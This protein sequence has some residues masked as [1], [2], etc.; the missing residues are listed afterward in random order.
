MNFLQHLEKN[1]GHIHV[2]GFVSVEQFEK[3]ISAIGEIIYPDHE[4]KF[5]AWRK[6]NYPDFKGYE[7]SAVFYEMGEKFTQFVTAEKAEADKKAL[8]EAVK[9]DEKAQKDNK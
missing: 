2:G 9:A 7:T 8:A 4:T 6:K 1:F 5:T 3:T